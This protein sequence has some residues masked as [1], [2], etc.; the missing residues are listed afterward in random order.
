MYSPLYNTPPSE[1]AEQPTQLVFTLNTLCWVV[2]EKG[3]RLLSGLYKRAGRGVIF[4]ELACLV[5]NY[6]GAEQDSSNNV[7]EEDVSMWRIVPLRY[8]ADYAEFEAAHMWSVLSSMFTIHD[9]I[10]GL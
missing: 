8:A 5:N 10:I 6:K 2:D 4:R 7:D 1:D 9:H 3:Y